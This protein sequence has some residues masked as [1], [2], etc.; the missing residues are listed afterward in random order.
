MILYPFIGLMVFG[1]LLL[2]VGC[3]TFGA[4]LSLLGYLPFIIKDLPFFYPEGVM[5]MLQMIVTMKNLS[6]LGGLL[7]LT[8][9]KK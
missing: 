7:L 3:T 8:T 2:S 4:K 1:G 5:Q 9:Y 6:I